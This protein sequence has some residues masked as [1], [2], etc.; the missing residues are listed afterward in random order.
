MKKFFKR[1][2]VFDVIIL[3]IIISFITL[4][5][6]FIYSSDNSALYLSVRTPKGDWIYPMNTDISFVVEGETGPVSIK[7][8][9]N[10]AFVVSSTCSNK[11]CITALKLKNYGDWNA[12]L[13]N[14]VFLSVEK[15]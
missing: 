11:T 4:T 12:C 2:K 6:L 8:E 1:I 14:K 15:K 5:A 7:I 13:P 9:N 10:E 3:A